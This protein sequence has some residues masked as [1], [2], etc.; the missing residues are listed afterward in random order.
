MQIK[1]VLI[2]K[3]LWPGKEESEYHSLTWR[4]WALVYQYVLAYFPFWWKLLVWFLQKKSY[5]YF[6]DLRN[7][8]YQFLWN[9]FSEIKTKF[10]QKPWLLWVLEYDIQIT[11]SLLT[12]WGGILLLRSHQTELEKKKYSFGKSLYSH[13][14][15]SE[16]CL[17]SSNQL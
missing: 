14:F 17:F 16:T 6:S 1:Y 5:S 4:G 8:S 7:L 12:V 13:W 3:E 2:K 15:T 11:F 10:L 9:V